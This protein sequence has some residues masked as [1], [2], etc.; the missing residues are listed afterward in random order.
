MVG[1][2]DISDNVG[3]VCYP[4]AQ[5]K[6]AGTVV[7]RAAECQRGGR[8]EARN[9]SSQSAELLNERVGYP[10]SG[11]GN[12]RLTPEGGRHMVLRKDKVEI[13]NP[14][15]KCSSSLGTREAIEVS[16]MEQTAAL[17]MTDH[18]FG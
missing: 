7:A 3:P 2:P 18:L 6:D 10:T 1:L 8:V 5:F 9:R 12:L 16:A 15:L 11:Q 4:N 14:R 13:G 17:S